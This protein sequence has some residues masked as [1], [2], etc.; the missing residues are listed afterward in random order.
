MLCYATLSSHVQKAEFPDNGP[1]DFKARLPKDR[2]WQEDDR[3]EVGLLGVS[4]PTAPALATVHP[5]NLLIHV[6]ETGMHPKDWNTGGYL[7]MF[8]F[9]AMN[10]KTLA[11]TR[12]G[13]GVLRLTDIS[14]LSTGVE[15]VKKMT[16]TLEQKIQDSLQVGDTLYRDVQVGDDTV[17]RMTAVTFKW[18]GDD[19]LL[20]NANVFT[21]GVGWKYFGITVELAL[22]MGWLTY[23]PTSYSHPSYFS[24]G[25]NM[26]MEFINKTG[27]KADYSQKSFRNGS[28][29]NIPIR[30]PMV[31]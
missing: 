18:E 10:D 19:L 1:S 11:K 8:S 29:K 9:T 2:L 4:L 7:C 5:E 27:P 15:F 31:L 30:L 22:N 20:D 23:H 26:L 14:P 28:L 3:W 13:R 25:P 12:L 16:D 17:K 6:A 24:R 21:R